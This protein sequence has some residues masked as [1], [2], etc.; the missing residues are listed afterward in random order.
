MRDPRPGS[1]SCQLSANCVKTMWLAEQWHSDSGYLPQE[2]MGQRGFQIKTSTI[3]SLPIFSYWCNPIPSSPPPTVQ[4]TKNMIQHSPSHPLPF[5]SALDK[6]WARFRAC[7]HPR[8]WYLVWA[9]IHCIIDTSSRPSYSFTPLIPP[10]L[11]QS[12]LKKTST[13]VIQ[14]TPSSIFTH[15][16]SASHFLHRNLT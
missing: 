13:T 6:Q 10:F 8:L 1:R 5:Q 11:C 2:L 7:F 14:A 3:Q 9:S 12:L 16:H 15:T 4:N